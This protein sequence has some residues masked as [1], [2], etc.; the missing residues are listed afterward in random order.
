MSPLEMRAFFIV[1]A[2]LPIW[3]FFP[4]FSQINGSFVCL[5]SY[6][7]HQLVCSLNSLVRA[8]WNSKLNKHV[9]KPHYSQPDFSILPYNILALF[10]RVIAHVNHIVK[11]MDCG[12][13]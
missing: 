1:N 13:H 12:M 3:K 10:R 2:A 6:K 4:D 11:K 7:A 8:V 9:S 5:T